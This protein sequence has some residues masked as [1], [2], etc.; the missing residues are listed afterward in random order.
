MEVNDSIVC[1]GY[2]VG[3]ILGAGA[4]ARVYEVYNEEGHYACKISRQKDILKKEYRVMTTLCNSAFPKAYDYWEDGGRGFLLME[5]CRGTVLAEYIRNKKYLSQ[6]EALDIAFQVAMAI[7]YLQKMDIP[8]LYRDIKAENI[9]YESGNIKLVDLG[10]AAYINEAGGERVG[11]WGYAPKELIGG[12]SYHGN[13][14][15]CRGGMYSDVYAFGRLFHYM[16]TGDSPYL[17]P[18]IKPGVREYNKSLDKRIE[19]LII[20]CTRENIYERLP[21]MGF[22]V[23]KLEDIKNNSKRRFTL[24]VREN[25]NGEY[26]YLKNV[27][28]LQ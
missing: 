12:E 23:S 20:E 21:D 19:K 18:Y 11:T 27:L 3:D 14:S 9:M 16:L 22:V 2:R 13:K 24:K 10:C 26:I 7:D 8:I 17:P 28:W 4:C 6:E 15:A 5:K 25:K 1:R